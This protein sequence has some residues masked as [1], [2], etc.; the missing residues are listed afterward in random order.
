MALTATD[1]ARGAVYTPT[2]I[3]RFLAR[4]S[5]RTPGDVALEPAAG[6]GAFLV[7]VEERF[8]EIGVSRSD[9]RIF[10]VEINPADAEAARRAAPTAVVTEGD[11]FQTHHSSLP[12]V[13]AVLGN[14]PYI[15]YQAFDGAIRANGDARVRELG[16]PLSGLASSWALFVIHACSF[17]G[18]RGRLALVLPAELLT[19][20]YAQPVWEF[21][22]VRFNAVSVIAFRDAAF[23]GVQVN[24]VLLLADDGEPPAQR[25]LELP[26]IEALESLPA[27]W[28]ATTV[29]VPN[30]RAA[31]ILDEDIEAIYGSMKSSK[32]F[33]ELGKLAS[34]DIGVVTGRNRY[35]IVSP[36]RRQELGIPHRFTLPIIERVRDIRGLRVRHREAKRLLVMTRDAARHPAVDA[37]LKTDDAAD[38]KKG[39]KCSRRDPWHLVPLPRA[40]PDALLPYMIHTS[41]R[42]IVADGHWS[43]NLVH[44]V[45]LNPGVSVRALAVAMMSTAT[46]FSMEMEGRTY[47]GG[48]LKLEPSEAERVLVPVMSADV[49]ARAVALFPEVDRLVHAGERN[50][51]IQLV[52][53]LLGTGGT[54]FGQAAER[55]RKRRMAIGQ[56]ARRAAS[57]P[58]GKRG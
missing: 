49:S 33:I 16:V 34:V 19:A 8:R 42:L 1:K 7:A 6:D 47:G 13:S 17:L 11:F 45:K 15:R 48:V 5:I 50:A 51:A 12:P 4:W 22:S 9:G 23:K 25:V 44:G 39:Y 31:R 57:D 27:G 2:A 30:R 18:P 41:P 28:R 36:A 26:S 40:V 29:A 56:S 52:D 10:A 14:P 54:R 20:Q 38:T 46:H 53:D 3:T 43:T 58:A 35:F 32:K 37:Y 55:L 21:L 24:A